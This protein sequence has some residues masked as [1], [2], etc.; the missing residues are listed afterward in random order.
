MP[1]SPTGGTSGR[2]YGGSSATRALQRSLES[3][4]RGTTDLS[5]SPEY[6]LRWR[7]SAIV[8]GPSICRLHASG[9][10]T[11]GNDSSGWPTPRAT[12]LGRARSEEAIARAKEKGGAS[13][14]DDT[15]LLAGWATPMANVKVRSEE[16]LEGREPN[17][18]EALMGWPT[19]K[20]QDGERGGQAERADGERTNLVDYA[21]LAGWPTPNATDTKG[22]SQPEGRRPICDNDLPSTAALAGWATPAGRDR[23][24]T[25]EVKPRERGDP[26]SV[27]ALRQDQLGRQVLLAGLQ[28]PKCSLG[29]YQYAHGRKYLNLEGQVQLT[30]WG[31]PAATDGSKAPP[32]HHGRNLTLPWQALASGESSTAV[33][34]SGD[35][36]R[37]NPIF[38][39]I[40]MGYPL[41]WALCGI[42][43]ARSFHSRK[44]SLA[45]SDCS[46]GSV[47]P[48]TR[49]SARSSSGRT[50]KPKR[51]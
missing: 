25:G 42:R 17:P 32:D 21:L 18:M 29:E 6:A 12:D 1:G 51:S 20:A 27:A 26:E 40:L 49:R 36:Y 50:S 10:R 30:G 33:T 38:S 43:A 35:G 15:A 13:S 31:T 46:A 11:S 24:D 9:H 39:G 8:L 4:L 22:P 37:L 41:S 45:A 2:R 48:S 23:K 47:M 28:T 7:N 19:P 44:A 5:G 14:L 3:R 16:F 34:A